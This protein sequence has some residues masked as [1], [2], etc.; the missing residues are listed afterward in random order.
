MWCRRCWRRRRFV[1]GWRR[2]LGEIVG[3]GRLA[4]RVVGVVEVRQ[5][6]LLGLRLLLGLVLRMELV[7]RRM[8]LLRQRE[9]MQNGTALGCSWRPRCM[10][11]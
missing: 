10:G 8:S 3:L 7:G 11:A 4:E 1:G 5:N 9:R 6:F 2:G